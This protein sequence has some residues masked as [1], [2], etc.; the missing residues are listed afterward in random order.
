MLDICIVLLYN[1]RMGFG[2]KEIIEVLKETALHTIW[3]SDIEILLVG[4]VAAMLTGQLSAERVT[5]DCDIMHFSPKQAQKA[6]LDAANKVA[7]ARGLPQ[8]WLNSQAM[9]LNV[10]PDGWRSRRKHLCKYGNL[11]IFAAS[12][13]DL[14]CMKFYANRPQDREDIL[15]MKPMSEEMAFVR[16]FLDML[17]L[18]SRH[19]DLDQIV[20]ALKLVDAME[21]VLGES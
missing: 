20:S 2:S 10:L 7:Q 9:Q 5:Q 21:E 13:L 14:L 4:G 19:A 17:R 1:G 3:D 15:E 16:R 11:S 18:P 8:N 6:I 12:R